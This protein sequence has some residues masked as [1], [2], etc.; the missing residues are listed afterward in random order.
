MRLSW[1]YQIFSNLELSNW[2]QFKKYIKSCPRTGNKQGISIKVNKLELLLSRTSDT[3][4]SND[5]LTLCFTAE[6]I[7][8]NDNFYLVSYSR[9][10]TM[11]LR[12]TVKQREITA[13]LDRKVFLMEFYVKLFWI[14]AY[15]ITSLFN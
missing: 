4:T 1:Q 6:K 9:N 2:R 12:D 5:T 7:T 11:Q 8:Q 15:E 10:S 3:H 14:L 13:R